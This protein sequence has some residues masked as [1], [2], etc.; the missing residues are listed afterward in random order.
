VQRLRKTWCAG[1]ETWIYRSTERTDFVCLSR[2]LQHA[3]CPTPLWC[4]SSD[5]GLLAKKKTKPIRNLKTRFCQ[6][7][8]KMCWKP[9]KCGRL[10]T[11]NGTN[12]GFG[13]SCAA[14][15]AKLWRLSLEIAVR[16]L[17][18]CFGSKFHKH[19]RVAKV[20]VISGKHMRLSFLWR[21]TNVLAKEAVRPI[22]WNVGITH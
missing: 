3:R 6:P 17:A 15:L 2:T 13:R 4:E 9:M 16:R 21:R 5:A 1:T 14:E 11:K 12:A 20:I 19:T 10:S 18:A 22:T 7:N 8:L